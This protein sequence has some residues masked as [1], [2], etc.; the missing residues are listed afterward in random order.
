MKQKNKLKMKIKKTLLTAIAVIAITS[1]AS[2]QKVEK[3]KTVPKSSEATSLFPKGNKAPAEWFT[4]NVFL[5]PLL[6]KDSNNNF[7]MGSVTF[8]PGSRTK[9]HSHPKG[10]VLIVTEGMGINQEKG[11]PVQILKKGDVVNIPA[12]V[13]HWH[14]ATTNEKMAH[15][16]ITN[17][18][19]EVNANW[20]EAVSDNEYKEANK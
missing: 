10:Q 8:E 6:P 7:V 18:D 1:F 12:N 14:G 15:I 13:P 2:A 17:Y 19:G 4:G 3:N 16:A 20:L 11:K 9:W 5:Q